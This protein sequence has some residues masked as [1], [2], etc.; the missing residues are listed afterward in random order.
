MT[1]DERREQVKTLRDQGFSFREIGRQLGISHEQARQDCQAAGL[2]V[3]T[4]RPTGL[5]KRGKAFWEHATSVLIWDQHETE[6]LTQVCRLLDRADALQAAIAEHGVL[7][8]ASRG[9]LRPNPAIAEER[10]LSLALGRLLAQLEIPSTDS[11]QDPSLST[12]A[13]GR[14]RRAAKA[15]WH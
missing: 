8:P 4:V 10:Q 13:Q 15:R 3:L 9:G 6:L 1:P 11:H 12:P 7:V 2:T 14:A 5:G